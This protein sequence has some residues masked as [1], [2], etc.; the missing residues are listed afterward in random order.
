MGVKFEDKVWFE[1]VT[2]EKH[3]AQSQSQTSEVSVYE[4]FG[5]E[6]KE[7]PFSLTI[8]DTPG[9]GDTRGI[10]Y[11][12]IITKKLLDL[13]SAP[14][15][16][17]GIKTL[18]AVGL[19]LKASENRLDERMA[20]IFN[21]VTSVF[22]KDMEKNIVAMITHSDGKTPNDAL[23]ALEDAN[24]KYAKTE[25]NDP[26][27]F[28]FNN[29]QKEKIEKKRNAERF[30][31][32]AFDIAEDGMSEFKDF[33]EKTNPQSLDETTNVLKERNR[34]DASIDNFKERVE[35]IEIQQK[36][37]QENKKELEKLKDSITNMYTIVKKT[38]TYKVKETC[39]KTALS[40]TKCEETCHKE[41]TWARHI[42]WCDVMSKGRCTIC[43]GKC[44]ARDHLREKKRYVT[45]TK[46]V[47]EKM[48][49]W[50]QRYT[51][52]EKSKSKKTLLEHL[53]DDMKQLQKDKDQFLDEAY[54]AIEQLEKIALN[55]DAAT[56]YTS[57]DFLI[58]KM[59]ERGNREKVINLKRK[60]TEI[61]EKS[62]GGAG[63]LQRCRKMLKQW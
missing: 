62:Q 44:S 49:D 36:A 61:E 30:A 6:S 26:V 15:D 23:K 34:L 22:G 3:R 16:V 2:D 25:A 59:E 40:C 54:E 4:I 20:Y 39:N 9:Y 63:Y 53:Q 5:F 27:Y 47:D 43:S 10:E 12:N 33:L 46:N 29:S 50:H 41:C 8:I 48:I 37:I 42:P 14:E 55:A 32:N 60:K 28:L 57:L 18:D 7:M 56:T 21:S 1:I 24:I 51:A 52:E 17:H 38:E 35:H 13:F 45:K 58:E 31:S 11:D 19:V